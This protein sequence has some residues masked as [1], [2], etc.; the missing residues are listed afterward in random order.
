MEV[1]LS[2]ID[3]KKLTKMN[4]ELNSFNKKLKEPFRTILE[5]ISTLR[6]MMYELISKL[7][8]LITKKSGRDLLETFEK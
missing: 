6:V 1:G 2:S 4:P 8:I 3:K 7:T 5:E